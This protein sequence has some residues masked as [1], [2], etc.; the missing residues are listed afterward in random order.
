MKESQN[1][2]WLCYNTATGS[3]IMTE[4]LYLDVSELEA[5]YS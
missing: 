1:F 5:M 4:P 2:S 3:C